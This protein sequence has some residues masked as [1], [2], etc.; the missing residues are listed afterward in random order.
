MP[1]LDLLQRAAEH[2]FGIGPRPAPADLVPLM[3]MPHNR[4]GESNPVSD[5]RLRNFSKAHRRSQV[6]SDKTHQTASQSRE[7]ATPAE[8][9][10]LMMRVLATCLKACSGG[11]PLGSRQDSV[12]MA[13]HEQSNRLSVGRH[14]PGDGGGPCTDQRCNSAACCRYSRPAR[15]FI[16]HQGLGIQAPP[17][18]FRSQKPG[19]TPNS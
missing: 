2:G 18:L 8:C 6:I 16:M 7:F 17:R 11:D 13:A 12:E 1:P 9:R 14:G 10:W 4:I 3:P 5:P 19:G 15:F